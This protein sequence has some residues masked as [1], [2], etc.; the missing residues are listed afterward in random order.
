[1]AGPNWGAH[2]LPRVGSEV[3]VSF[4]EGD[5]DRPVV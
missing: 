5:I 2:H 3:L 1:M 4:I